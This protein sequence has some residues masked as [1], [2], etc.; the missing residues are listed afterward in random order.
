MNHWNRE[1]RAPSLYLSPYF[2]S[3]TSPCSMIAGADSGYKRLSLSLIPTTLWQEKTALS[4][5]QELSGNT[6]DFDQSQ[7]IY[8]FP[9]SLA[10]DIS[11]KLFVTL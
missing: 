10:S 9:L 6:N 8:L 7:F 1:Y 2:V 5:T 3:F 11:L 4:T